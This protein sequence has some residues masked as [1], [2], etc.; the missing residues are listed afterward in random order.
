MS[1]YKDM[2]ILLLFTM[3]ERYRTS[4]Y[5]GTHKHLL[6]QHFIINLILFTTY[7]VRDLLLDPSQGWS[8]SY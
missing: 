4:P 6:V 3:H 2:L 7:C 5:T 8:E 1:K